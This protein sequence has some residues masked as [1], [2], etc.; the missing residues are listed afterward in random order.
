MESTTMQQALLDTLRTTLGSAHVLTDGDLSAYER[1][2]RG[3]RQGKALAVVRPGN[4]QEVAAVI[5]ACAAAGV[6]IVPQGGNT[7]LSVGSTPDDSGT[8]IIL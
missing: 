4:T 2:W 1:D 6:A 7:G 5:K 8:Q 3:R